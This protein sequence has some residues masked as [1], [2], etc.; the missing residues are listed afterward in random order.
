MFHFAFYGY[1]VGYGASKVSLPWPT[2]IM[3][4]RK[5]ELPAEGNGD[6]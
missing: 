3:P 6:L 2:G 4:L 5:V 1:G